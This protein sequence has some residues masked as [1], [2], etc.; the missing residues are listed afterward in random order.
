[1]K[2]AHPQEWDEW[3]A[4]GGLP[5]D[6]Y[7]TDDSIANVDDDHLQHEDE[8]QHAAAVV[9]T[10]KQETVGH[11]DAADATTVDTEIIEP[12]PMLTMEEPGEE[13]PPPI[14]GN[15]FVFTVYL[16]TI[17]CILEREDDDDGGEVQ[18]DM[19]AVDDVQGLID[20]G[21]LQV[22]DGDEIIVIREGDEVCEDW[23]DVVM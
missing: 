4:A 16:I 23:L 18:L 8:H 22:Q 20:S 1:M 7:G 3:E 11:K 5:N 2:A 17:V 12:P 13:P 6:A 15:T 19:D 14:A 9:A 21:Q 10:A